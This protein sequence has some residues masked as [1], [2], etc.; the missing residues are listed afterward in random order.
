MGFYTALTKLPTSA[1]QTIPF[2]MKEAHT[3]IATG[4]PHFSILKLEVRGADE[5]RL[6]NFFAM[7]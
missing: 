3:G 6:P 1:I 7:Q 4:A 5:P 2:A